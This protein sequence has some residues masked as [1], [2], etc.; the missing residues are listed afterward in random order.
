MAKY[1]LNIYGANDEIVKSYGTNIVPWAIYIKAAEMEDTLKNMS[2]KE[3]M[4][5][6]GELLKEVFVGLTNEELMHADGMDVMN[7]F[8]QIVSGGQK[9]NGGNS[10]NA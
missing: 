8:A 9:I 5:A 1:E 3:Q 10:K 2:A 6:V 7:T 4:N